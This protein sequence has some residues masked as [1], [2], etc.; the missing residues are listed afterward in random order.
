[1]Y[2]NLKRNFSIT[3]YKTVIATSQI[4]NG[5]ST[6]EETLL[7][8]QVQNCLSADSTFL[9]NRPVPVLS[10]NTQVHRDQSLFKSALVCPFFNGHST[11]LRKFG[12]FIQCTLYKFSSKVTHRMWNF[13][14]N[15]ISHSN[16]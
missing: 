5:L 13:N 10:Y 4:K 12:I 14:G 9:M 6:I 3:M 7:W 15:L 8:S 11:N 16:F 2:L 1:M